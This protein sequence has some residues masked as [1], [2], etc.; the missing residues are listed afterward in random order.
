MKALIRLFWVALCGAVLMSPAWLPAADEAGEP[1]SD[2]TRAAPYFNL[3]LVRVLDPYSN[4]LAWAG[5]WA[6][7][8]SGGAVRELRDL[9]NG[10]YAGIV[11][12][13]T[14][15]VTALHA[16]YTLE[17]I[18][19][20][21]FSPQRPLAIGFAYML[22]ND[23]VLEGFVTDAADGHPIYPAFVTVLRAPPDDPGLLYGA[24]PGNMTEES[25]HF[26]YPMASGF[27]D[28]LL[29]SAEGYQSYFLR[30][31]IAPEGLYTLNFELYP[32]LPGSTQEGIPDEIRIEVLDR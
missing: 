4:R 25:G 13:G 22:E 19:P 28:G 20:L 14:T 32:A 9:S 30:P 5:V 31:Y 15:D 27:Y 8:R 23:A 6:N 2:S 1:A 24:T 21:Y 7:P 3:A 26:Y 16:D 10:W 17:S 29:V 12:R 18:L 11:R